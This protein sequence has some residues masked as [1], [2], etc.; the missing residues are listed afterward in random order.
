[1]PILDK[2][3][4]NVNRDYDPSTRRYLTSDPIGL[5]GGLNTFG[6]VEGNPLSYVDP[7][8]LYDCT[9]SIN[10]HTMSCSPNDIKNPSFN[11]DSYVSG[12]NSTAS[13]PDKKCQN[14]S[15]AQGVSNS[16]PIPEGT[17]SIGPQ[18]TP[19]SK[20]ARRLT[21]INVPNI[22]KRGNFDIHGCIDPATCSNGCISATGAPNDPTRDDL[23]KLLNLEPT[24]KLKVIQ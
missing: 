6:Y 11:S 17:Y 18:G 2:S 7:L 9:Y 12:N 16:G 4:Y 23:N 1:L 10:T 14:N 19:L 13:Y 20:N 15:A 8:G 24:N 3:Y 5:G 22:G 21:P